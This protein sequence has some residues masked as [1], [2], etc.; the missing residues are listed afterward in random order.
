MTKKSLTLCD[1][2]GV[3]KKIA[4][5]PPPVHGRSWGGEGRRRGREGGRTYT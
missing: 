3:T 1:F 2:C 4:P 5:P